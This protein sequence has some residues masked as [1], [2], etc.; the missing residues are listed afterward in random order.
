MLSDIEIPWLDG[1]P[2]VYRR[3]LKELHWVFEQEDVRFLVPGHG[4]VARGR[5]DAY[6]RLLR[7]LDYLLL[8]EQRV[9]EARARGRSLA[10]TQADCAA[11]DYLGKD[12]AYAMNDVHRD[13][14]RFTWNGLAERDGSAPD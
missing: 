11:M 12:A 9:A 14:V 3:T 10:E 8:L 1:P 5:A 4:G 2:W 7:D 6:R 13:N